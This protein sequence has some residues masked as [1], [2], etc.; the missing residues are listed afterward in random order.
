M[1]LEHNTEPR[2]AK[3][4]FLFLKERERRD[5]ERRRRMMESGGRGLA[6]V[7]VLVTEKNES[8]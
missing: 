6:V 5:C 2:L 3:V 7:V 4:G 1:L 8:N